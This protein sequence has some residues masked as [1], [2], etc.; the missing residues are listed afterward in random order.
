D[1]IGIKA[2]DEILRQV[3]Q[4]LEV[5]VRG[6]DLLGHTAG[7]ESIELKLFHSDRGVFSLLL[8]RIKGAERAAIVAARILRKVKAPMQ[9]EDRELIL[10][11]SIGLST[12]PVESD[13]AL[14]LLRLASSAK[15][16][17]KKQG[18]DRFLFSS[19]AI[20]EMYGKRFR[21]ETKLRQ[22]LKE[23]QFSLYYQP[24]VDVLTGAIL[25]VEALIRWIT[26]EGTI[27][28]AE[29]IPLAE[30]TGLMI[31]LGEWILTEACRQL[32][33]WHQVEKIP[34]TLSYNL[35]V[36]QM[37][38]PQFLHK[39][40]KIIFA[41]GINTQFLTIE[42]TESLLIDDVDH[43]I[44]LLHSLKAWGLK[45]SID[46][47]GTGYSSFSYLRRLPVDELKIDRSFISEITTHAESQAI[48]ASIIF[49][50]K[51]LKLVTVAE[52]IEKK[53]ELIFLQQ[54]KCE[55]F[56]GFIF[57]PAI[58]ADKLV[59]LYRSQNN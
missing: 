39:F 1:T 54:Q 19:K 26:P 52:G 13:D 41:S 42:V 36:S 6:T 53:E 18:G 5:I 9:V 25:G 22:A 28:P 38:D 51:S 58:P 27:S 37:T 24:K 29:F 46:D 8:S 15:D 44:G 31:P 23:E 32:K 11:A 47:F 2:G 4:R 56:Q 34:I 57:S 49:L 7:D 17:A 21:L 35:S 3:A 20:S 48:I 12:Y 50:A 33:Q 16:Y 14:D 59:E 43:K 55:Q 40:K 30:E 10:T 45:L